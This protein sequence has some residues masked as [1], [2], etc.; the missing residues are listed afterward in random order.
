MS[1]KKQSLLVSLRLN[2]K[3]GEESNDKNSSVHNRSH[4]DTDRFANQYPILAAFQPA[5]YDSQTQLYVNHLFKT[6]KQN[7]FSN[8]PFFF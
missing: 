1:N 4:Q 5:S 6:L 7:P 2:N 3:Y 8:K